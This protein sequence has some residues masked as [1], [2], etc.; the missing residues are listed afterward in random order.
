MDE[1]ETVFHP[2]WAAYL[3]GEG[4]TK[5]YMGDGKGNIRMFKT[6][7][8]MRE[9]L[10]PLLLPETYSRVVVHPVDVTIVVPEPEGEPVIQPHISLGRLDPITTLAPYTIPTAQ[11]L[12]KNIQRRKK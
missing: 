12:L 11:E 6:E 3:P 7:Q 4:D 8:A 10:E 2:L 1:Q 9:Y 5:N